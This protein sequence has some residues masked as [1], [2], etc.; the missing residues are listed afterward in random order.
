MGDLCNGH[1]HRLRRYGDPLAGPGRGS[2][3]K[4]RG[5]RSLTGRYITGQGYVRVRTERVGRDRW[6]LEHRLA[7][8]EHLGR[9]LFPDETV[10]HKDLNR[11]NNALSNLELWTGSHPTGQRVEDVIAW[12]REMLARYEPQS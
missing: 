3:G 11:T 1:H 12:C 8:E 10:H 5:L 4:K 7:M 2:P 6:A 9:T